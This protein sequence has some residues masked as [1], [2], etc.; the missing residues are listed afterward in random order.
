MLLVLLFIQQET[1][2]WRVMSKLWKRLSQEHYTRMRAWIST[3][4]YK[5]FCFNTTTGEAPATLLIGRR[6][7]T[8][9]DLPLPSVTNV[10]Q[11]KQDK[12]QQFFKGN[13]DHQFKVN[14]SVWV[15]D[16]RNNRNTWTAGIIKKVLGCRTYLITLQDG[17]A[18]VKKHLNQIKVRISS[19]T[20]TPR[21]EL[22]SARPA[23]P[24]PVSPPRVLRRRSHIRPPERLTY[25]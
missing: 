3:F 9:L 13:R 4:W 22:V 6:L 24:T 18:E 15:R 11:E 2:R 12:Q 1:D 16:Y 7:R 17:G 20:F 25:R 14:D 21:S 23:T 5:D 10:V 19:L 8:R